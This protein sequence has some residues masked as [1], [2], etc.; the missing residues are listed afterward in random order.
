MRKLL[1]E[2]F[3]AELPETLRFYLGG[4][5]R[6]YAYK[7]CEFDEIAL[8][9]GLYFGTIERDGLRLSIEGSFIVGKAAGKNVIELDEENFKRW[10]RGEDIEASVEGYWIVKCGSYFAGCGRGNGK[11]LRNFVPKDRRVNAE[12]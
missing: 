5:N 7:S 3:D 12:M 4:K 9:K 1:K 2:Q 8:Q 10:M 6:V 11:I